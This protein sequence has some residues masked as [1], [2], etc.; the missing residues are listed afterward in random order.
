[1]IQAQ[2]SNSLTVSLTIHCMYRITS[3]DGGVTYILS[4]ADLNLLDLC[5]FI[6][7]LG[8]Y[9]CGNTDDMMIIKNMYILYTPLV[10]MV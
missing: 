9:R 2:L 1:M 10:G 6:L 7:A 8:A 3:I 5:W 4:L